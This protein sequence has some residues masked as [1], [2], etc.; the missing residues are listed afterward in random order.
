M[1]TDI[2][3]AY[4]RRAAEYTDLL[5]SMDAVHPSDRQLVETWAAEVD[6][7]VI[8]AGCGPGHWSAHIAGRGRDV[9]GIDITPEFIEIARRRFPGVPFEV[10]RLDQLAAAPGSIG[11]V[12]AWYSLIHHDRDGVCAALAEFARVIHPGGRLLVGF[13]EG[14]ELERFPHAVIT[15]YRWP[16]DELSREIESAGFDVVE[17][18]TRTRTGSRTHGAIVARRR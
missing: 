14:T 4:A 3:C 6:G 18:H 11:G 1:G 17:T 13:F 12:L 9:S 10:G 7:P 8:D 5:G 16:T 2:A 15:A